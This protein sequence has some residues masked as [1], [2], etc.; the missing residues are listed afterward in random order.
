VTPIRTYHRIALAGA[1][2]A[3]CLCVAP[4][5]FGG[6]ASASHRAASGS[7]LDRSGHARVG[8][9]SFYARRFAGRKMANGKPMNP[10]RD[11]AASKTLPLGTTAKVTNL[12]TG[13]SAVVTIEDRGPYVDGRIVDL[14]P[15]TAAKIGL[16][17]E[18][19]V[20]TVAVAP[21]TVPLPDGSVKPGAGAQ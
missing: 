19:G 1:F 8:K 21:I 6:T 13:R 5:A 20:T 7:K 9:A 15:A 12:E 18:Q 10:H 14:T 3:L 2:A 11:T 4:E 16:T 17:P